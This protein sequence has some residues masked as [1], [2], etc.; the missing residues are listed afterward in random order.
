MTMIARPFLLVTILTLVLLTG[1]AVFDEDNRRS[2]NSLDEVIAPQSPANQIALAPFAV[3][4]ASGA[5]LVDAFAVNPVY[6]VKP[7]ALDTYELYWKPRE[8]EPL[9]RAMLFV[10]IVVLTP[11]TFVASWFVHSFFMS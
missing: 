9:T 2:L 4:V 1:C 3:P 7:A 8:V 5:L 6:A 11:P 10:P